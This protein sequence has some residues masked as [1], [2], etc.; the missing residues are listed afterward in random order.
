MRSYSHY[1]KFNLSLTKHTIKTCFCNIKFKTVSNKNYFL[2]F[3]RCKFS[4]KKKKFVH[5]KAKVAN[6]ILKII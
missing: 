6:K 5:I 1:Y 4:I 3:E 2:I